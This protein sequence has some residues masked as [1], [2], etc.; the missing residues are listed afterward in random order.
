M[1]PKEGILADLFCGP[2]NFHWDLGRKV[3]AF[4]FLAMGVGLVWNIIAGQPVDLGPAGLGG[5]LAAVLGSA[6]ALIAAKDWI[7]SKFSKSK[8]AEGDG[9]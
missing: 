6:A 4:C 8:P 2:G 5:G 3:V 9:E 7:K 1:K